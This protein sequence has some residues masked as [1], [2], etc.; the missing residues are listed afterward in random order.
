[1]KKNQY[2]IIFFFAVVLI[3]SGAQWWYQSAKVKLEHNALLAH[4]KKV[5]SDIA[6]I[7]ADSRD[8]ATVLAITLS[9]NSKVHDILCQTCEPSDFSFSPLLKQL[10]THTNFKDVWVQVI[11]TRGVSLW[12]SWSDK[13]ND[14]LLKVRPELV[15]I[16]VSPHVDN[17]LSVGKFTLSFKSSAPVVDT[18]NQL[19]GVVEIVSPFSRLAKRLQEA[20]GIDSVILADKEYRNR[21]T[22]AVTGI[23]IEDFYVVNADAS[24]INKGF[25]SEL[26]ADRFTKFKDYIVQDSNV[27]GR[28]V[29]ND[30]QGERLGYWFT[31][32]KLNNIDFSE[33][34][35][36][37]MQYLYGLGLFMALLLVLLVIYNQKQK[38]DRR[39]RY[40]RQIID[41]A[42]EIIFVATREKIVD[43]N[44]H[45]FD[46]YSECRNLKD[47][48]KKYSNISNT[49]EKEDGCLQAD[50][51]GVFWLDY[52]LQNEVMMHKVK[53][54]K[55]GQP[56]YFSVQARMMKGMHESL[57][58]VLL[59]D[60]TEQ[61]LYKNQLEHISQTDALTGVGNRLFFNRNLTKEIQRSHRYHSDLSLLIF[62]ID[63]FKN[64][65]DT[66]G[67][68]VGD[69]VLIELA[70]QIQLLLRET[71]M[72]CRFGGEEFT[73]ILPE[74]ALI[75]AQQ[76][77]ER[78]RVAIAS[79]SIDEFPCPLT[80]SF[81]VAQMTK[82]DTEKT[83]LKRVDKALYR[84]KSLGRNRIELATMQV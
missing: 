27:I 45:F 14:S 41:S 81:G 47:F 57:I 28:H 17:S 32:D 51:N 8:A 54:N 6:A 64:V 10:N 7:I 9:A 46:F 3:L 16:L 50:M 77:A 1:M 49:F 58:N 72:L 21:L 42:S 25:L 12:R 78:L 84:A 69:Q 4:E 80:L 56:Y 13:R 19:K 70:Q 35:R 11:D 55:A 66:Y 40:N 79:L 22:K 61:E 37:L 48:V 71:D 63:L 39:Q 68:D 52:V 15:D 34:D 73:I 36:V 30:A 74:T 23:F 33:V 76:I 59:Q 67:H 44:Q 65:N 75:E 53:I 18:E 20:Y 43:V 31:F 62:D 2:I 26:G 29:I 60:I 82:W 83:L 38:S 24:P 5:S